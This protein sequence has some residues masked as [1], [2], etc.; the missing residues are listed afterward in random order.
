[1]IPA[2]NEAK[3]LP[4]YLEAVRAHL[5][6]RYPGCYEVIVVDD[7]SRDGQ[8]E[9][10]SSLAVGWPEL[11]F[12]RHERNQ[13]K[14]AAVRTGMLAARGQLVLFA[15]ADGATPID[16]E[17]RLAEAIRSGADVAIGS[18][19]LAADGARRSR[20]W[21]RK[22]AG[23]AFA[24][25]ARRLLGLSVRDTQCGFKMFRG[26]AGRR[27]FSLV[28]ESG[29]LFDLELLALAARLGYTVAEVP[30]SWTEIA[31]GHLSV[32]RDFGRIMADL[33]RVRRRVRGLPDTVQ[34]SGF[35]VQER[36]DGPR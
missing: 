9:V 28:Q 15:D 14:G 17:P 25:L 12:L 13:G 1:V 7:G 30:V 2:Y 20:H 3:R 22:V 5:S 27:L 32:T 4:P 8:A 19:L 16:E 36:E 31:G 24:A 11:R 33:W 35:R 29:Y 6:A 10:L 18:R 23:R 26:E 21:L 34:G